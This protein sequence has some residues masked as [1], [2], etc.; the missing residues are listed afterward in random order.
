MGI[1]T[2]NRLSPSLSWHFLWISLAFRLPNASNQTLFAEKNYYWFVGRV[3]LSETMNSC[4]TSG[5]S[6]S[7]SVWYYSEGAMSDF[8]LFPFLQFH[9]AIEV[10]QPIITHVRKKMLGNFKS[11]RL[12]L[13]MRQVR[14]TNTWAACVT[15]TKTIPPH[16]VL[17]DSQRYWYQFT[18]VLFVLSFMFIAA[19]DDGIFDE[20]KWSHTFRCCCFFSVLFY[21]YLYST[22]FSFVAWWCRRH[23][24]AVM[25]AAGSLALGDRIMRVVR[26][27]FGVPNLLHATSNSC[28]LAT[29]NQ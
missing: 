22:Q 8:E 12:H 5:S 29:I 23:W 11:R 17:L 13:F 19:F 18:R 3:E 26:S 25:V 20:L 14:A 21:G 24:C 6:W 15:H 28:A 10:P 4:G 2:W 16:L 1:S 27:K 9:L 7:K